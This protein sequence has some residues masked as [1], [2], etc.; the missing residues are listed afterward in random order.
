MAT[1]AD[2]GRKRILPFDR[3]ARSKSSEADRKSSAPPS[4]GSAVIVSGWTTLYQLRITLRDVDPPIWRRILV[5]GT[6]D[7]ASLHRVI[8]T[9]MG[10]TDRD[11]EDDGGA[12]WI[13]RTRR[14]DTAPPTDLNDGAST[15]Q[16][17]LKVPGESCIY[18]SGSGDEWI[19]VIEVEE[20]RRGAT[21]SAQT[22]CIDGARNCPPADADGPSAY[23]DFLDALRDPDHESHV[24]A[25]ETAG[26]LF[27]PERF[28][29]DET[30]RRLARLTL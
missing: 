6:I 29:L 5:P 21:A 17:V 30:N 23:A 1:M 8:H 11:V 15:L 13:S 4:A 24:D 22:V 2:G 7:L 25:L 10:W 18:A 14:S 12:D 9:T 28:D 19:H 3:S 20:I 27:D 26:G 16:G